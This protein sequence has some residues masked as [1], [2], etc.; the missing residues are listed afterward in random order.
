M[1]EAIVSSAVDRI[2]HL[3]IQEADLLLGVSN[4][5]KLLR[6]E[7]TRMQGFLQDA[8]RKQEQD[9]CVRNWVTEIRDA[10]YDAEDII[11]TFI[12]RVARREGGY[13]LE[14]LVPILSSR[15]YQYKISKLIKSIHGKIVDISSSMRSYGIYFNGEGDGSSTSTAKMNGQLRRS[16]L[17]VEEELV[18]LKS[19]RK[20]VMDRLM[21][22]EERFRV[23]SIVGFGGL[24]K[25]TL[26]KKVYN[27][28]DVSEQFDCKA[29]VF[30]SQK[31]ATKDVL[32]SI[33]IQ[34]MRGK[35]D[36][37][38]RL[39]D[40]E[41][42]EILYQFL[43]EKRYLVVLDNIYRKE[44]WDSLKY[45]FPNG[46]KGS[47]VLLTTRNREVAMHADPWSSPIEP[48]LLTNEESWKLFC[49]KA[50]A[51]NSVTDCTCPPE[52]EKIGR[53][54]VKKCSG[55]TLAVVVLAGILATKRSLNEWRAVQRNINAHL[56]KYKQQQQ[57]GGI[58]GILA[59]SYQELPFHLKPC[60]LYFGVFPEDCEEIP[61]K[62]L[63]R[64]WIAEGFVS[65]RFEEDG[66]ETMEDVAEKYLEDLIDRCMV[67]VGKWESTGR[68]VKTCCIHDL[69][70]DL[71]VLKAREED[72][73]GLIQ[74]KGHSILQL[75]TANPRRITIH[76]LEHSFQDHESH[77][78]VVQGYPH[79]RSLLCFG[80]R[81]GQ[82]FIEV[83]HGISDFKEFKLLRVL[84]LEDVHL[85]SSKSIGN[86]FHLRYLGLTSTKSSGSLDLPPHSIADLQSLTTLDIRGY[87]MTRLSNGV[88][89]LVSLRHLLL[90]LNQDQGR[91][92]IDTLRK[93]ETLKY[94]SFKNLIRGNAMLKLTSLRS[95]GVMFKASEEADVVLKSPVMI[96][97]YLRTFHMWMM[98]ANAFSNLEPLS[99]CQY[100]NKLKI[101]GRILDGNLEYLPITLSKLTLFASKLQQDPMA[102]LEKLPNLT[103]L[104]L[105][106]D[107][108]NG[109][110]MVC[111]V[112]GFPCLEILE[113]TGL[114]LQEW[115]VTEGAMPSLRM[116]YIRNLPRL[117]MIPEGLMSISTL[118]HL[119]I[120]GM[121]R[122]LRNRIKAGKGVVEGED[123]YKVQHVPFIEII[124]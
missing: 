6:A 51:K 106:E 122:T 81:Y 30:V 75:A 7:L 117:K 101:L 123:F 27:Q 84:H 9:E 57:H 34:V 95:L 45:V 39:K 120:S 47:K 71:C 83:T 64:L 102:V 77:A 18:S 91:F 74:Q 113:I 111:S 73:L 93:L 19:C 38:G 23:V 116:L 89:N 98:S 67:Q 24:G 53:E 41:M 62:K 86:L 15:L 22:E 99:H 76:P 48:R 12:I 96:S 85:Y 29:W 63:I 66:E 49:R 61:K 87:N 108:Y 50:F 14:K 37:H 40:E 32:R 104:H 114:D 35:R 43:R 69:M 121:T 68:G 100:L 115:E 112:N 79:L 1:A 26:A 78:P 17:R 28:N 119:A 97:G 44:V 56:N 25:T 36:I 46:K 59:L 54:M 103:F 2:S 92:Q 72:F 58:Y 20:D 42:V 82:D 21:I 11:N 118:Q 105:G 90:P 16:Y 5:V 109:S 107:S 60:F 10:A 80:N 4:E 110:K 3:L 124:D 55:L 94:I 8:D 13:F 33:L 52:F 70:R 88:S 31:C 65:Q